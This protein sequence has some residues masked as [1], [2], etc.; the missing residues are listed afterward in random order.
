MISC[1]KQLRKKFENR[2]VLKS[3]LELKVSYNFRNRFDKTSHCQWIFVFSREWRKRSIFYEKF[4]HTHFPNQWSLILRRKMPIVLYAI[5]EATMENADSKT[6]ERR[7]L[8]VCTP[9][10]LWFF[11]LMM[12]RDTC[13]LHKCLSP[14]DRTL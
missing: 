12:M 8:C 5:V 7:A 10:C 11:S 4:Q 13:N 6:W 9:K 2:A 3:R 1:L 14:G